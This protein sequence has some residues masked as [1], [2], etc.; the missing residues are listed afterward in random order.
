M[1]KF[2]TPLNPPGQ[3]SPPG[4]E[5]LWI[6]FPKPIG[7]RISLV[8]VSGSG[9]QIVEAHSRLS[10]QF[11]RNYEYKIEHISNTKNRKDLKLISAFS[12]L[13]I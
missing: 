13:R 3:A 8:S 9:S 11:N 12:Q 1:L 2:S 7:Y 6:E 5:C 4:P 10:L